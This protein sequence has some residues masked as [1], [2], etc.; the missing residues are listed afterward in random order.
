MSQSSR[1][2]DRAAPFGL[3]RLPESIFTKSGRGL[4]LGE[5][6]E[7]EVGLDDVHLGEELL[8][9]LALDGGVD[10]DVVTCRKC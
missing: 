3:P 2:C 8:G 6:S 7:T 4:L 10:D 9:L 5:G 1:L